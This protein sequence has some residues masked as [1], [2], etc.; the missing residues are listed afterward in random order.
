MLGVA[1][2]WNRELFPLAAAPPLTCDDLNSS[3]KQT[4][5]TSQM[6]IFSASKLHARH[7]HCRQCVNVGCS[8]AVNVN[9]STADTVSP[10]DENRNI[11]TRLLR[12]IH[13]SCFCCASRRWN[14]LAV[15]SRRLQSSQTLPPAGYKL[16][17]IHLPHLLLSI[18]SKGSRRS[19]S[20]RSLQ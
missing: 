6:V 7:S 8:T 16:P 17:C 3:G 2:T 9:C 18:A 1:Q 12:L 19:P 10:N 14:H 5:Q 15:L 11:R 20:R 4:M 13:A